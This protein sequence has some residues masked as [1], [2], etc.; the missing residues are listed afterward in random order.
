MHQP[1][2]GMSERI[3]YISSH[4][5]AHS[6]ESPE[7]LIEGAGEPVKLVRVFCLWRREKL[8]CISGDA[9]EGS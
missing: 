3:Q 8:V 2:N 7:E 4:E 9:P 6:G 1:V 5:G